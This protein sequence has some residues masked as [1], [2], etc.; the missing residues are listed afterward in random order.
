MVGRAHMLHELFLSW[1]R[2]GF[3]IKQDGTDRLVP[4]TD[5]FDAC[6]GYDDDGVIRFHLIDGRGTCYI[7]IDLRFNC[8]Q[9][10]DA[11]PNR[12]EYLGHLVKMEVT[13]IELA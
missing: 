10:V 7:K 4:M 2:Y 8:T 6:E 9:R 5:W 12:W 3:A 13:K 11:D 1:Q